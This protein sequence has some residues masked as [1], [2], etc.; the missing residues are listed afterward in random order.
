MQDGTHEGM[1]TFDGE[2]E[3]MIREGIIRKDV[4]MSYASNANNLALS[5]SDL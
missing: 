5:L 2:L 4:A 1:Q 3:R